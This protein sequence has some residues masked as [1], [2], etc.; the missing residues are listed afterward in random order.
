MKKV[1]ATYLHLIFILCCLSSCKVTKYLG[2]D[3]SFL[4]ENEVVVIGDKDLEKNPDINADLNNLYLQKPNEKF[5][6]IPKQYFYYRFEEE[7]DTTG[8][9]KWLKTQFGQEPVL[10]NDS[11]LESTSVNISN[12]LHSRG[13]FEAE[14]TGLKIYKDK[15]GQKLIARYEIDPKKPYV[16]DSLVYSTKDE[17]ISKYIPYLQETS[18]L[19][20]GNRLDQQLYNQESQRINQTLRE[21]GF[22]LFG[23][24]FINRLK[25]DSTDQAFKV[26]LE[27]L[28]PA[29]GKNHSK[30]TIGSITIYPDYNPSVTDFVKTDTL[31][32]NV[33]IFQQQENLII[34]KEVLLNALAFESG[35]IYSQNRF[36]QTNRQLGQLE[37]YGFVNIKKELDPYNPNTLNLKIYLTPN[38]RFAFG[39]NG[40]LNVSKF[41]TNDIEAQRLL[42]ISSNVSLQHRNLLKGAE[43][44]ITSL[45]A[46][47][48]LNFRS[49]G[50]SLVNNMDINAA[51]D[52]YFPK[53]VDYLGIMKGLNK[54]KLINDRAYN[55]L[56]SNTKTHLGA[57]YSNLLNIQSF[58][59]HSFDIKYGY[60]ITSRKNRL[61]KLDMLGLDFFNPQIEPA[62]FDAV[63][64]TNGYLRSSFTKQF[65]TGFLFRD[66]S[67][68]NKRVTPK[69]GESASFGFGIELSGLEILGA[70]SLYNRFFN[71]GPDVEW[72]I[73]TAES[74]DSFIEFSQYLKSYLSYTYTKKYTNKTSFAFRFIS[75]IAKP[76]GYSSSIPFVKQFYVGGPE[77]M[78]G[79]LV[80]SIGPGGE[81]TGGG[82]NN[83][84]QSGDIHLEVNA[85]WRLP[86][87]AFAGINYESAIFVDM[88]NVWVLYPDSERPTAQLN[89]ENFK[90]HNAVN[91]GIGLRVDFTYFI[92]RLDG[93]IILRTPYNN[94]PSGA[95]KYWVRPFS[96]A[97]GNKNMN[98]NLALGYP[99]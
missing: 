10:F 24:H 30:Y 5:L 49:R 94:N 35:K 92:L 93:G 48:A 69:Y 1:F 8:F 3:E 56:I 28:S 67:F 20:P 45:E 42:G 27:I 84:V 38:K 4:V 53:Y 73:P 7:K 77:S 43:L 46:G 66:F 65:F 6:G 54:T 52:L 64:S 23:T 44:F 89:V 39:A 40:E 32:P 95:E 70:N 68:Q 36:N 22:A 58:S 72:K 33:F 99:F 19:S 78:R 2:P 47:V 87:F 81:N 55:T 51:V 18:L 11:I 31:A 21:E 61:L 16:I 63:I 62:F 9:K 34:R 50:D 59:L 26:S 15:R 83:F 85:E 88:G 14:V 17:A 91:T 37:M 71:D 57:S 60:E 82:P 12:Y 96:K 41:G 97:V 29:N 98:F 79:W 80:R 25:V 76:V 13:Y 86:L 90:K 75:G 74:E